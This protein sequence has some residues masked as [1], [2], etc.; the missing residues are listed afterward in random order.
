MRELEQQRDEGGMRMENGWKG[1]NG[2]KGEKGNNGQKVGKAC[3]SEE[4][5]TN[6]EKRVDLKKQSQ[7]AGHRPEIRS[8]K[9]E[10]LNKIECSKY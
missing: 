7:Y 3:V 6:L 9:S 2:E 1:N 5:D 4:R 10:I 8:S